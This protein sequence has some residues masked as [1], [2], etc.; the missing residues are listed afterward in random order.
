MEGVGGWG[1]RWVPSDD[2][3]SCQPLQPAELQGL[4]VC[5]QCGLYLG[6]PQSEDRDSWIF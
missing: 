3:G 1:K 6:P 4:L 2:L 5:P